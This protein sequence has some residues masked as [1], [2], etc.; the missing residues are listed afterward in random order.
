MIS[1]LAT[2]QNYGIEIL[3]I[4]FINIM[5]IGY[6]RYFLKPKKM[7]FIALAILRDGFYTNLVI[8]S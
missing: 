2:S 7:L 8:N 1:T 4:K 5:A 3:E 6:M